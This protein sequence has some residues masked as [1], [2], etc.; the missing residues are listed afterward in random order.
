V[1]SITVRKFLLNLGMKFT[2][3]AFNAQKF[4]TNY[5]SF[6][7][8]RSETIYMHNT[9]FY[10]GRILIGLVSFPYSFS[11]PPHDGFFKKKTINF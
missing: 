10:I 11:F 5:S 8:T 6:Q 2:K 4:K 3:S 1:I 7:N 9:G